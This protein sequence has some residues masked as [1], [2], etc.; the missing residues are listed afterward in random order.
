M[1]NSENQTVSP[2]EDASGHVDS[3]TCTALLIR[4]IPEQPLLLLELISPSQEKLGERL[5]ASILKVC[6]DSRCQGGKLWR[7]TG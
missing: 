5:E 7:Q 6:P 3:Q 2:S 4:I 1:V